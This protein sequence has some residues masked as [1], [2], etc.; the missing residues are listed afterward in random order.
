MA[1]TPRLALLLP[2]LTGSPRLRALVVRCAAAVLLT[3]AVAPRFADSAIRPE[4]RETMGRATLIAPAAGQ[5]LVETAVRFA[6]DQPQSTEKPVLILSRA[7]FDPTG[8]TSIPTDADLVVT[9]AG[10]PV[11][12]M[13]DAGFKIAADT[14]IWWAVAVRE[15]GTGRLRVSEVREFT[16]L[17]KFQNRI[18][19]SPLLPQAK[20]GR[21]AP[22]SPAE[23]AAMARPRVRLSTGY[24]FDA[25]ESL[26]SVPVEL[27]SQVDDASGIRAYIVQYPYSPGPQDIEKIV[28]AGGAM[29]SYLPDQAYLVRMTAAGK[30]KLEADGS[31]Y[32]IG[33]YQPAFKL[34]ALVDRTMD[35]RLYAT[36]LFDD[37]DVAATV[38]LLGE[39]GATIVGQ[40]DNGVN[41]LVRFRATGEA[42]AALA[43]ISAVQWI[44]PVLPV[45][46]YNA[47]V[48]WVVQTNLNGNRRV[49]D[50]GITGTGQVVMTSDSGINT[51]HNAFRDAGVPI[52]NFGDFLT[53]RKVI[54]Y[55]NG[56]PADPNV[57]FGDH[58]GAGSFHGTHT[59]G[60]IVGNDVPFAAN[61]NDGVAI[62][63]KI[64]FMDLSGSALG[65][66]VSPPADL[67]DLFQAPYTGNGAGAA[68][69]SS[70]SWGASNGGAYDL[71][72]QQADQFMWAHQDFM[73]CFA[74][75]NSGPG[76]N[77]VGSPAGAKSV[78][79]VGGTQNGISTGIYSGSSRGPTDDGRRKPTFA[80]PGQGVTSANGSGTTGY[81]SFT[82]TSMA[83]PGA[84][85]AMALV[86]DYLA[87][88]FYPSGVATPANAFSPSAAL[89][90]AIGVNS[91]NATAVVPQVA[92]DNHVGWGKIRLDDALYFA[93]DTRKTLLV[94][95]TDGLGPGT[96][97]EYDI[98]V[99]D[100][101]Q[102]LEISLC[103][104][105]Y[106][107][108][109]ASSPQLVNNL[110][111]VVTDP[112]AAN[113]YTGNSYTGEFS[114]TLGTVDNLNV[115][116]GVRVNNPP[117]GI[118]TV[119]I[120]APAVP[121]GPQPFGLCITGGIS[122]GAGML[123]MDRAQYGSTSTVEL[124]V[125]DT[126]AGGSVNVELS[127]NT[128]IPIELVSL[129]LV[130][131][132]VYTG[133][134]NL[135]TLGPAADGML[136]VSDGDV[137]TATYNDANPVATLGASAT[138]SFDTPNITNVLGTPNGLGNVLVT[139]TTD[140]ASNSK[141]YYGA[142]PALELGSV[143]DAN[144]V[145]NHS[146]Q[147]T[148][149]SQG[150]TY[151]FDVESVS[152]PGGLARDDF[153]GNHYR[154]S[155][156][157]Q[158]DVLLLLGQE[159]FDRKSTWEMAFQGTGIAY[160]VWEGAISDAAPLGNTTTGLRSYRAVVW[161]P[162]FEQYPPFSDFQR[163]QVTMYL[164]EG[165]RLA[166]S[167]HDVAW[168]NSDLASPYY[169]VDRDT[170][171]QN[172]LHAQYITDPATWAQNLGVVSDPISGSYVAGV[173]Y[174]PFRSG[175][176]GDEISVVNGAGTG[177][178]NW[179]NNLTNNIGHRW[180]S[181]GPLGNPLN[182]V[183]GGQTS[184]L[185]GMFFE[186]TA[187]APPHTSPSATRNDIL[188]KTI[189]YLVGRQLPTVAVTAP[190][191]GESITTS[192][193]NISWNETVD[194]GLTVANRTLEYSLDGGGSWT[195]IATGV[196]ASPYS[197]NL[198]GVPNSATARVRVKIIDSG[199]PTTSAID[200]SDA[201]FAIAVSGGDTQGPLVIA[202]SISVSP[203]PIVRPN[204]ANL[205]ALVS[206]DLTGGS[207]IA[208][209]EWSIGP[210]PA[211]P[212][213]G[214]PMSISGASKVASDGPKPELNANT[215]TA[216]LSTNAFPG[217][218]QKI[219]VRA[220]DNA[221]L[222]AVNNW[223]PASAIDIQ[224]N[225]TGSVG[226]EDRIP[227]VAFLAPNAPNPFQDRTAFRFGLPSG[228]RATLGIYDVQGRLVRKI[229][230]R[231]MIAG[232]HTA[233]WDGR[234]ENGSKLGPG[235]YYYRLVTPFTKLD[236][237][238]AILQ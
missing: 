88:G 215:A 40:W 60:T 55:K 84:G 59:A 225:G 11:M 190:N 173:P 213:S 148:G 79:G 4:D 219:W 143:S 158:A 29:V 234:D 89:L 207:G 150:V 212:G 71:L 217:G 101:T 220:R 110:N 224:I 77:T 96:F 93:G 209:A 208:A 102:A 159:G 200:A 58:G 119:R 165:G 197:W 36:R 46:T 75:G 140:I 86:R 66:G 6:F 41:K 116:E 169:T 21:L 118:W 123:A 52:T 223:G 51:N 195:Q 73:I 136:S 105:D 43:G 63:A 146:I 167:S 113:T 30:A 57:V 128:E 151:Y 180:E 145:L 22:P 133:T 9:D 144:A 19:R 214:N 149:L 168:S 67:N 227:S 20:T 186:F 48:Q 201:N 49:W 38:A 45:T 104:T 222:L 33:E 163:D 7:S 12:S 92:P 175:G 155:T 153:G 27:A 189:E 35:D 80:T 91:G 13:A 61:T 24:D 78:T 108:N 90:K 16:A 170:W 42:L 107:G 138:V 82:G 152:I 237:R 129:N 147:L 56:N 199:T 179:S 23:A 100:G 177:T 235:V 141:V 69:V 193:T 109:P 72:A 32:W 137:I 126:N 229:V 111:L 124:Q 115:E 8:W 130:G 211:S 18:A 65:N 196:G 103:W 238:L 202:G 106:P 94:D 26:P 205:S 44:E 232:I 14:R 127:S 184:R 10:R 125:I 2:S 53:H 191:G 121:I 218:A 236:R 62:N 160:D 122:N 99:T 164:D 112:G 15:E 81:V 50:M 37:A 25:R 204:N 87:Q 120:N 135:T 17:R 231:E 83:S 154:V 68:R 97:I 228:G 161:Q 230:D 188:K 221:T 1:R 192:P 178:L 206:D 210:V 216:T 185:V 156:Q 171:T 142:T 76:I 54:A 139:W 172:T 39:R 157:G 28:A 194:P 174:T 181:S 117:T 187:M 226:V 134:I 47:N 74:N 64:Y 98:N 198:T 233:T 176:A 5:H 182:A 34:S 203:N 95:N 70:N 85:G 132:G 114:N 166:V 31:T 183:W 162:G 131:S 3:I